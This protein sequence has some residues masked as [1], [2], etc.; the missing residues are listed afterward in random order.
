WYDPATGRVEAS[1]AA[2][3]FQRS[4]AT[5]YDELGNQVRT[6]LRTGVNS[7]QYEY[8]TYDN[9]GRVEYDVDALSNVT[10]LAYN[11]FGEQKTVTRYSKSVGTPPAGVDKPWNASALASALGNDS[12][13][14]TIT[15]PHHNLR[16]QTH[17]NRPT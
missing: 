16:P 13:A 17:A 7:Y 9:L 3:R 10:A 15:M 2:G 14:R 4:L 8:K 5:T 6:K 12:I 1:A 11:A